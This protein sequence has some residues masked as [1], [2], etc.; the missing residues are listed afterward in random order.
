ML[1]NVLAIG[2]P[3]FRIST[4][5]ET[6]LMELRIMELIDNHPS[7]SAVIVMG[8][9]HHSHSKINM[10]VQVRATDFLI[11][12]SKRLP[13]YVLVGNHDIAHNECFLPKEHSLYPLK[14]VPSL[15]I[16]DYP[17]VVELHDRSV[18]S[19]DSITDSI[20]DEKSEKSEKN[21]KSKSERVTMCPFIPKNRFFEALDLCPEWRESVAVFA[22][23]EVRGVK[24]GSIESNSTDI[25]SNDLMRLFSGHVHTY[26][27]WENGT[28]IGT[29][30][31]QNFGETDPKTVSILTY[32][33]PTGEAVRGIWTEVRHNLNIPQHLQDRCTVEDLH[34]PQS[35]KVHDLM[36]ILSTAY[37]TGTKF[38]LKVQGS[39]EQLSYIHTIPLIEQLSIKFDFTLE[40]IAITQFS[41]IDYVEQSNFGE[42]FFSY[43]HHQGQGTE[44]IDLAK[45]W[46]SAS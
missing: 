9:I 13:T 45:R 31:S 5:R 32:H 24:L 19:D 22:H 16:I 20:V 6:T 26:F 35:L 23:Q 2:D 18:D 43:L 27:D 14:F 21:M 4:V 11:N 41:D 37:P 36:T 34:D 15:N 28:Y 46:S 39:A 33:P 25:W 38:K 7:L 1:I 44:V 17:V 10:Q 8:D 29:P 40:K 12:L 3:H 42:M 30:F